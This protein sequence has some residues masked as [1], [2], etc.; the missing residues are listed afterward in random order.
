LAVG[1]IVFIG[2]EFGDFPKEAGMKKTTL[3]SLVLLVLAGCRSH[4]QKVEKTSDEGVEVVL[5]HL[6]PYVL[7]GVL[8]QLI[9]EKEFSIDTEDEKIAQSGLTEMETFDVDPEGNIYIMRWQSNENYVFKFDRDGNFLISFLRRGQG[10]GELEWGGTVLLDHD[11][12]L[13]TKDPSKPKLG[14]YDRDG[15]FIKE[16]LLKKPIEPIAPLGNGQY[17]CFDQIQNPETL[18]NYLGTCDASFE[19]FKKIY[20]KDTPNPFQSSEAKVT[21]SG[22][23]LIYQA[24]KDKLYIGDTDKGYEIRV[25]DLEGKLLRKIRKEYKPVLVSEQFKQELLK[26]IPED[27]RS[28]IEFVAAW[29][30]FASFIEDEEGRLFVRTFEK[31]LDSEE[32]MFDI[33]TPEGVFTGRV[34]IANRNAQSETYSLPCLCR[35]GRLYSLHDKDSGYRELT[36]YRLR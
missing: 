18:Q 1:D 26:R 9:L 4:Q 24:G 19:S 36:V 14:I 25:Y 11:G 20:Q 12:N 17:F 10:P 16:I 34:S 30:A 6:E 22:R 7:K 8:S 2:S 32:N 31:A 33:F 13:L 15:R 3:L 21:I 35:G 5:N 23:S 28:R 29:P 27:Y